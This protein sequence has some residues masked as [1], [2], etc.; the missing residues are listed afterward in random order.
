M[1][2]SGGPMRLRS[3]FLFFFSV[4]TLCFAQGKRPFTFEDMMALKRVAEPVPSPDGKWVAFAAQDV[5][6]EANKKTPHI[7]LVP[8][9]GGEAKKITDDP[10]GEDRPRFSP[11]GKRMIYTS[12]KDG[13]SQIWIADF[14]AENGALTNAHR[15]TSISTEAD[16]A[17]WSPDGKNILFVSV[18]Y[19]DCPD[20]AC[21]KQRE[22]EKAKSKVQA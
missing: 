22:E 15:L 1:S 6:L 20:D 16:G 10:A 14:D 3:A 12:A 9:A 8:L 4:S 2:L 18:V 11:D 21:N 19:P 13:S 7:W 17:V 5:D